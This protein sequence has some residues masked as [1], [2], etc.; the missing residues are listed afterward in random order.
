MEQHIATGSEAQPLISTIPFGLLEFPLVV[1]E[2]DGAALAMFTVRSH[3]ALPLV[4]KLE[5]SITN[6][7]TFQLE[8]KNMCDAED[9]E[10][11]PDDWNQLFGEVSHVN[12]IN[13]ASL[14]ECTIVVSYRPAPPRSADDDANES[15][16][17]GAGLRGGFADQASSK[18]HAVQEARA[19]IRLV[20]VPDSKPALMV[21]PVDLCSSSSSIGSSLF[22]DGATAAASS[23]AQAAIN[24]TCEVGLLARHCRSVLRVDEHELA[25]DACTIGATA[26]KDFTV[27]NCS[28]VPLR[29]RLVL[30]HRGASALS[31]SAL[32]LSTSS[33]EGPELDFINADSAERFVDG[34]QLV[35]G[36]S[37][38]RVRAHLSARD[39][40]QF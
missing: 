13:L 32:A 23:T 39:A 8:N 35:R 28:E 27:W 7:I 2:V 12:A 25:F 40:G 15:S 3:S 22:A 30:S 19:K 34:S 4:V 24:F 36:Y 17:D 20:A 14:G 33:Y 10:D 31:T 29:F 37:H 6:A 11:D 26:V 18:R 9:P 38:V 5:A 1:T 21:P 16:R